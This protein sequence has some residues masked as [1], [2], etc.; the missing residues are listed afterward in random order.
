MGASIILHFEEN[1][2]RRTHQTHMYNVDRFLHISLSLLRF[3]HKRKW[4]YRR[5][6]CRCSC[7]V[8]RANKH[9]ISLTK[10]SS[11][12]GRRANDPYPS[13][14]AKYFRLYLCVRVCSL[15]IH[16]TQLGPRVTHAHFY[17][18]IHIS[19]FLSRLGVNFVFLHYFRMFIAKCISAISPSG[20]RNR[21]G[22]M[23]VDEGCGWFMSLLNNS[24]NA[25]SGQIANKLYELM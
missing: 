24:V 18:P 8:P 15:Q 1:L 21:I 17:I 10:S 7:L 11:R 5:R 3:L 19:Q 6:H 4:I 9:S 2:S 13:V 25:F 22:K 16:S 20:G 12:C 23:F 14:L